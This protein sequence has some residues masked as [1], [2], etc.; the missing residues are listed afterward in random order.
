VRP[1]QAFLTVA[2]I[3]VVDD[4]PMVALMIER[5]LEEAH[6]VAIAHTATAAAEKLRRDRFD[7][8]IADLH[9]PD[10]SAMSIRDLLRGMDRPPPLLVLTGGAGSAE[11]SAFLREPGVQWVQKPFRTTE[12]LARLDEV[13]RS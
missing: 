7:A 2:R 5:T 6:E 8:V 1:W 12:L 4:E 9:L 3:L 11:E 10:G 13:L